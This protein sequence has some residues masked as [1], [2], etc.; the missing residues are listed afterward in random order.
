MRIIKKIV[1]AFKKNDNDD[2]SGDI[3]LEELK[4]KTPPSSGRNIHHKTKDGNVEKRPHIPI[5]VIDD[6]MK[7]PTVPSIEEMYRDEDKKDNSLDN[8]I[9]SIVVHD[10]TNP[11]PSSIEKNIPK[12]EL[13]VIEKS[14]ARKLLDMNAEKMQEI[15]SDETYSGIENA[16]PKKATPKRSKSVTTKIRGLSKFARSGSTSSN[17][18]ATKK[19][20]KA[21]DLTEEERKKRVSEYNRQYY[22]KNKE[23][24]DAKSRERNKTRKSR[25]KK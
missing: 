20:V 19:K 22:L 7:L 6:D 3:T 14:E 12:S 18:N 13:P 1:D 2:S 5:D 25:R 24:L 10:D 17:K 23:H 4:G 11:P 15:L 9:P 21:S 8:D 16:D